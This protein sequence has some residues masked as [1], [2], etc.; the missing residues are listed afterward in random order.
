[1]AKKYLSDKELQEIINDP[2]FFDALPT[3]NNP[4]DDD[5]DEEEKQIQ[6]DD[7][8]NT[9]EQGYDP[10]NDEKSELENSGR[11]EGSYIYK[12]QTTLWRKVEFAA[13]KTKKKN[14]VKRFPAP[15]SAARNID[16]EID[17]FLP[18]IDISMIDEI[19]KFK[20]K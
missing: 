8:D 6:N 1:M 12:D 13:T 20:N 17:A 3:P 7:H 9:S 18:I 10:A 16:N 14:I 2:T 19:V 11:E 4:E 15:K 5:S